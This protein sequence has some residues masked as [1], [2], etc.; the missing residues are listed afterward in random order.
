MIDLMQTAGI[1]IWFVVALAVTIAVFIAGLKMR[2]LW[3][4]L[5]IGL[6]GACAS[7]ALAEP[8]MANIQAW[9]WFGIPFAL[10]PVAAGWQNRSPLFAASGRNHWGRLVR[11]CISSCQRRDTARPDLSGR[12]GGD[13]LRTLWPVLL[14]A[15]IGA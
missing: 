11:L 9:R 6:V 15:P 4:L 8:A 14:H 13:R 5:L 3:M 1:D 2:H 7:H 12:D 10:F